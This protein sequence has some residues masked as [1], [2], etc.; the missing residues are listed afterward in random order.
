MSALLKPE[1]RGGGAGAGV[2]GRGESHIKV[3]GSSYLSGLNIRS[4]EPLGC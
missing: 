3:T 4:W 2:G 1:N